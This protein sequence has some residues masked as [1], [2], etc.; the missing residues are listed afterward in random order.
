[1]ND[2]QIIYF[3]VGHA[4][5][6]QPNIDLLSVQRPVNPDDYQIPSQNAYETRIPS[7]ARTP[8][9]TLIGMANGTRHKLS[10]KSISEKRNRQKKT[11]L[12]IKI[13]DMLVS[14]PPSFKEL[15]KLPSLLIS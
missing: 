10:R 4:F 15:V 11:P 9:Y 13:R 2:E 7:L 6:M 5:L 14:S 8:F 1:M 12:S 3:N